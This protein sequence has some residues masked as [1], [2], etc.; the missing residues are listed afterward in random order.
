[1]C[2]LRVYCGD[3]VRDEGLLTD[4]CKVTFSL[5]HGHACPRDCMPAFVCHLKHLCLFFVLC[6]LCLLY[7]CLCVDACALFDVFFTSVGV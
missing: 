1:M 2:G 5:L 7:L 4:L 3:E 6:V